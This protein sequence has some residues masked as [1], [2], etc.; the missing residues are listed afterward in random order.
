MAMMTM[1]AS[2]CGRAYA[3]PHS[4]IAELD[5]PSMSLQQADVSVKRRKGAACLGKRKHARRAFTAPEKLLLNSNSTAR[6]QENRGETDVIRSRK[7]S[8]GEFESHLLGTNGCGATAADFMV[9][10]SGGDD[11]DDD[12][13]E[14]MDESEAMDVV[15]DPG[16][17][18]SP[19]PMDESEAMDVVCDPVD[20][21][22]T[23]LAAFS[24][25][26]HV[27][28][29]IG[30]AFNCTIDEQGHFVRR[31]ARLNG[32]IGSIWWPVSDQRV[33]RRSARLQNKK[34]KVRLV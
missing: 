14:P 5:D 1:N 8:R 12:K 16:P 25:K 22:T 24:L 3:L 30:K 9:F 15:C 33:Q 2:F 31:S 23:R 7:R 11:D 27:D 18:S 28:E 6:T 34:D 17:I 20:D 19:Q 32:F 26:C 29:P 4:E 21:L 10:R 13:P